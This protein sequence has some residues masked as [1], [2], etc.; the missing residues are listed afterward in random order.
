MTFDVFDRYRALVLPDSVVGIRPEAQSSDYQA[1]LAA[2]DGEDWRIRTARV[3]PTKPGAFVA[4]WR[5]AAD[6]GTEPFPASD[7]VAG[8][9]VLV[10][11]DDRFGAFRF[12]ASHLASLGV[13]SGPGR[14][15]LR[16][17]RVYPSWCE[18]L[19]PQATRT[20]AA[21]APAWT[22]LI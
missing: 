17:F 22:R 2:I 10:E 4:V 6:G 14:P 12:T 15:G 1:G 7:P 13:T 3:T 19:N 11:D 20:Q 9:L 18:G 8:L 16:G 21:Q 5:R